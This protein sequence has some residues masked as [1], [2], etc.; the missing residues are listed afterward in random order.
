MRLSSWSIK[1]VPLKLVEMSGRN[2]NM[3][4]FVAEYSAKK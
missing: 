3:K 1:T 2:M 4:Q